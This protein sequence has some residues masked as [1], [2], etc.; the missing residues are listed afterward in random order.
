MA[1]VFNGLCFAIFY[2]QYKTYFGSGLPGGSR[3]RAG[4]RSNP[5]LGT[6]PNPSQPDECLSSS[7]IK[8][9]FLE[10]LDQSSNLI[11]NV[12]IYISKFDCH[13][14][15]MANRHSVC[16]D[17]NPER[18][19][20]HARIRELYTAGIPFFTKDRIRALQQQLDA[21]NKTDQPGPWKIT[22][23]GVDGQAVEL[24]IEPGEIFLVDPGLE[25]V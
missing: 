5:S 9:C 14:L 24:N 7:T 1:I 10:C 25:I 20:A 11:C 13:I 19:A 3:L 18:L 12:I 15:T 6:H 17:E 8:C 22:V 21:M 2:A 23:V 16:K 4:F